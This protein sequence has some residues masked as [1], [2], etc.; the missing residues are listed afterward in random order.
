MNAQRILLPF[1][2]VAIVFSQ[3]ACKK[4]S[5]ADQMASWTPVFEDD[6]ENPGGIY[7]SVSS[8]FY[9]QEVSSVA[10][11]TVIDTGKGQAAK[12]EG[13]N[14]YIGYPGSVLPSEE[15]TIRFEWKAPANLFDQYNSIQPDWVGYNGAAPPFSGFI[16]DTVGW[17]SAFKG[18]FSLALDFQE[19]NASYSALRFGTWSG[20][21]WSYASGEVDSSV[22]ADN[23]FH[24]ILISWSKDQGKLAIYL[25]GKAVADTDYNVSLNPDEAFFIG[26]NPWLFSDSGYWP[27]G[28]HTLMGE[29]AHL[30]IYDQAIKQ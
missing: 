7:P 17:N 21:A 9:T 16:F 29:Y 14:S 10:G 18:G 26:H 25:D 12:F 15:G 22:W 4:E 28:P 6:F 23:Q 24:E 2:I 5:I 27:Y 11:V 13:Y 19:S 3:V 30:K 1:L 8:P 20:K